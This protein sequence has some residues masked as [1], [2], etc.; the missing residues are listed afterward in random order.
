MRAYAALGEIMS[1][2]REVFGEYREPSG[3]D[4][5]LGIGASVMMRGR[6][7]RV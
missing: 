7:E 1:V 4:D 2:F 6:F 3:A 5:H